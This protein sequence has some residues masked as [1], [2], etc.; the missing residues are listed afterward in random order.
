MERSQIL[1][2]ETLPG[3][4]G[5]EAGEATDAVEAAL[6]TLIRTGEVTTQPGPGTMRSCI[7]EE[8]RPPKNPSR[9]R[10][11]TPAQPGPSLAYPTGPG[12]RRFLWSSH[13]PQH[14]LQRP[15]SRPSASSANPAV[16]NFSAAIGRL[17]ALAAA[18]GG[19]LFLHLGRRAQLVLHDSMDLAKER[20]RDA[21]IEYLLFVGAVSGLVWALAN[22]VVADIDGGRGELERHRLERRGPGDSF[23]LHRNGDTQPRDPTDL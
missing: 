9:V 7:G 1:D 2:R 5:E 11:E 4:L 15:G 18:G 14:N 16:D 3:L 6:R 8:T 10:N 12:P 19:L 22:W 23:A 13:R 21:L 20:A 17:V